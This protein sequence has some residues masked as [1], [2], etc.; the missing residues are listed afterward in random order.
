MK[1][2]GFCQLLENNFLQRRRKITAKYLRHFV[3]NKLLE[4][5]VWAYIFWGPN[6]SEPTEKLTANGMTRIY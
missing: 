5:L 1:L 3:E 6:F 2:Y 4:I